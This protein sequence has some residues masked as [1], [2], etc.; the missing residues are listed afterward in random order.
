[1]SKSRDIADSAATINFIDSL[2]SDAQSQLDGKATL[3]ASPTF[4]GTVTA[5]AFSGDGSG[6]T[7]VDSLPSQT[8]NSGKFLTTDGTV[9]SWEAIESDPTK[10]AFNKSFIN[11]EEYYQTLSSPVNTGV[12]VVSL[13]IENPYIDA[14]NNFWNASETSFELANFAPSTSLTFSGWQ[15]GSGTSTEYTFSPTRTIGTSVVVS[16]D[17]SKMY[18][19]N[20][21]VI[22]ID[23]YLLSENYDITTA[24]YN[25]VTLSLTSEFT[26][27]NAL[28]FSLDGTKIYVTGTDISA[29][30][31]KIYQYNLS[32][33]WDIT[34]ASYSGTNY[35]VSE[36]SI[37]HC[38]SFKP[39]GT[40]MYVAGDDTDKIYQYN[41]SVAWSISSASY[42][43]K[44]SDAIS[45]IRG[46]T[47]TPDGTNVII[48]RQY[49]NSSQMRV[50][51]PW[52]ASTIRFNTNYNTYGSSLMGTTVPS[53][54]IC[55]YYVSGSN[56]YSRYMTGN[57]VSLGSGTFSSLDAGSTINVDGHNF[58]VT[59]SINGTQSSISITPSTTNY[60][61]S[62]N[63]FAAG[64]W[65]ISPLNTGT[66]IYSGVFSTEN[67]WSEKQEYDYPSYTRENTLK[68]RYNSSTQYFTYDNNSRYIKRYTLSSA[69]DLSSATEDFSRYI[70]SSSRDIAFNTNGT[71]L[72]FLTSNQIDQ[73]NLTTAWDFRNSTAGGAATLSNYHPSNTNAQALLWNI[74]NQNS[75]WVA[76]GDGWIYQYTC[77]SF[78]LSGIAAG[79]KIYVGNVCTP[80]G[81]ATD[82]YGNDLYVLG[83]DGYVYNFD[84]NGNWRFEGATYQ[85]KRFY[86]GAGPNSID[87]AHWSN[88]DYMFALWGS[89]IYD[90]YITKLEP[91]VRAS[92]L[93]LAISPNIDTSYWN[94][95][96]SFSIGG[97]NTAGQIEY[98]AVSPDDKTTWYVMLE[99]SSP[100]KI[101]RNNAGTWEYNSSTTYG[102]ETWVS[103]TENTQIQA[104]YDAIAIAENQMDRTQI[105][106]V[107]TSSSIVSLEDQLSVAHF[108]QSS[109][110]ATSS[111]YVTGGTLNYNANTTYK[112][113]SQAQMYW[114]KVDANTIKL[115]CGAAG[116]YSVRI[117]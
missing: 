9:P 112:E 47:F 2:T 27:V 78:D 10:L 99:G 85:G 56:V 38:V 16:E 81:L 69:Y 50:D 40:V 6:L 53:I 8:G 3:D 86:L 7:G 55:A 54:G 75:F 48:S 22:G 29:N 68:W 15:L 44:A 117:V 21:D 105:N 108:F 65:S 37:L 90:K 102:S 26:F 91:Y 73:K 5:T 46:V 1:M 59:D 113:A 39:D 96:S 111:G 34:T 52:D 17:G 12:P 97:T 84:S 64:E 57:S 51:T 92:R 107:A 79:E 20:P 109:P 74:Y 31:N 36:D 25:D 19:N 89:S 98:H 41:L 72:W 45:Y 77:S 24:A 58:F 49:S 88:P 18:I 32:V 101:A 13:A 70:G 42:S 104:L 33:A 116:N 110:V 114:E 103:A 11:N 60:K 43:S 95:I 67:T 83:T 82:F 35:S 23:E 100:R 14:T 76:D 28:I 94:S 93:G 66:Y 106:N 4:A 62:S 80:V 71:R 63:T 61:L 30:Q 115:T 87:I